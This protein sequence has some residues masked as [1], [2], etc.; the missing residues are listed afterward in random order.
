MVRQVIEVIMAASFHD[1]LVQA[2]DKK[3]SKTI[4]FSS[5]GRRVN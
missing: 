5:Y 4:R 2:R 3:H 1:Q